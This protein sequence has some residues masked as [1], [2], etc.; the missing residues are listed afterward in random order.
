MTLKVDPQRLAAA[1]DEVAAIQL[2]VHTIF[3]RLL[4]GMRAYGTDWQKGQFGSALADG[5][6]GAVAVTE[7]LFI[8]GADMSTS[9]NGF[10]NV[11]KTAARSVSDAD[12]LGA[13]AVRS[14]AG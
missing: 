10:A 5:L 13:G 3:A 1:A 4:A 7:S 14:T 9:L 12:H 8:G 6:G 2:E 11:M